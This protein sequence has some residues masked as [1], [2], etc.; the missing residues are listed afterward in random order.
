MHITQNVQAVEEEVAQ[1]QG[2]SAFAS[3]LQVDFTPPEGLHTGV[4]GKNLIRIVQT[5]VDNIGDTKKYKAK[6]YLN[7]SLNFFTDDSV[8]EAFTTSSENITSITW[9]QLITSARC[10][11]GPWP[12]TAD[13]WVAQPPYVATYMSKV[14]G[15]VKA[16]GFQGP[17]P[18]KMSYKD[19]T[20]PNV[21][22][23]GNVYTM[24]TDSFSGTIVSKYVTGGKVT[25]IGAYDSL[26][27]SVLGKSDYSG[28]SVTDTAIPGNYAAQKNQVMAASG[29]AALKVAQ[30]CEFDNLGIKSQ[31]PYN[32]TK[33]QGVVV[34]NPGEIP[35]SGV[36]IK[37]IPDIQLIRER[38]VINVNDYL[39]VS[40]K[41]TSCYGVESPAGVEPTWSHASRTVLATDGSQR[42]RIV[43]WAIKNFN[44]QLN[45]NVE[46]D[47][48]AL[49]QIKAND[50]SNQGK[51]E[52]PDGQFQGYYWDDLVSG[53]VGA[54]INI[55]TTNEELEWW[56]NYG[57]YIIAII[58]I[59]G[60]VVAF[61]YLFPQITAYMAGRQQ[62]SSGGV[63]AFFKKGGK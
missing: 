49:V 41:T 11:G 40:T 2:A 20:P 55:N 22:I 39:V 27:S 59:I 28:V 8:N 53:D 12:C 47:L 42:N 56:N 52:I 29:D 25:R 54:N 3:N 5:G 19:L 10:R 58:G 48:V 18:I 43:G 1:W 34:I 51:S 14:V 57:G 16:K 26:F 62:G 15:P 9:L 24:T 21:T 31:T 17:I 32:E 45:I 44:L 37:N 60:G 33:Q 46:V 6:A 23:G 7:V 63:S 4:V 61:V 36:Y 35:Q 13:A 30:A 50:A 38:L